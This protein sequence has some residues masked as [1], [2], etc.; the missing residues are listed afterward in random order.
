MPACR[1][2]R[3]GAGGG[4]VEM[5]DCCC[6]VCEG[7]GRMFW[8]RQPTAARQAQAAWVALVLAQ[9]LKTWRE[10]ELRLSLRCRSRLDWE[11]TRR[12]CYRE[13]TILTMAALRASLGPSAFAL[14][15]RQFQRFLAL[16]VGIRHASSAPP[17]KPR[18]LEKPDRFNPPSHPSRLRSK[19]RSYGAPLPEHERRAQ[20]TRSYPHMM[21]AEGTFIH[22]FLTN[23]NIHLWISIVGIFLQFS[24][25]M[26]ANKC[27]GNLGHAYWRCLDW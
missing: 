21:P 26:G 18:L 16:P 6:G 17:P 5:E 8:G 2:R 27:P 19:H 9:R 13:H 24:K 1:G 15:S 4:E 14:H 20:K 22:W 23:R 7:E 3:G 12:N 25:K 10:R 11:G